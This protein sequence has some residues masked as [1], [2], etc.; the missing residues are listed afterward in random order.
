MQII[1]IFLNEE[2]VNVK[3]GYIFTGIFRDG[4]WQI[5]DLLILKIVCGI[6]YY[7]F[8]AW[9]SNNLLQA[10]W[11]FFCMVSLTTLA[12]LALYRWG[13]STAYTIMELNGVSLDW[14]QQF[15]QEA[16]ALRA[17]YQVLYMLVSTLM[18]LLA[19]YHIG[20]R[21]SLRERLNKVSTTTQDIANHNL[22]IPSPD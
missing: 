8:P 19:L 2:K 20:R 9:R 22:L 4:F 7:Q 5:S 14:L 1:D 13:I 16:A 18:T 6:T 17:G 12:A 11:Q 10:I 3:R 15:L 21:T